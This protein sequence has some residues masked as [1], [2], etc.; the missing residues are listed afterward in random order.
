M[1]LLDEVELAFGDLSRF[2]AIVVG[3]RAYELRPDVMRSNPQPARLC[4]KTAALSSF[5]IK[6]NF[7]GGSF[8]A[9][10]TLPA[11]RTLPLVLLTRTRR[12]VSRAR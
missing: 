3:F 9:C 6:R 12:C 1:D 10:P 7:A 2:D 4:E 8:T 5:S 11:C